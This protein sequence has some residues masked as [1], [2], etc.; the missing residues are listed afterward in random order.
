MRIEPL[1]K[2]DESF[3]DKASQYLNINKYGGFLVKWAHALESYGTPRDFVYSTSYEPALI[4]INNQI[5]SFIIVTSANNAMRREL[6]AKQKHYEFKDN[7]GSYGV[8]L[9]DDLTSCFLCQNVLQAIDAKNHPGDVGDNVIDDLGLHLILPNRYPAEYGHSLSV[10]RNH[11][12]VTTRVKPVPVPEEKTAMYKPEP[13]KT[14]GNIFGADYLEAAVEACDKYYLIGLRNHVL[15]GMSIPGHDHFQIFPED[16][17]RFSQTKTVTDEKQRTNFGSNVYL[18]QNTPFD[19]LL[20]VKEEK[21]PISDAAIPLLRRLEENDQIFTL[22]Y[23]S[24]ILFV[25]PRIEE[26]FNDKRQQVGACMPIH[27]VDV[28]A[29]ETLRRANTFMPMKGQ[30]DWAKYMP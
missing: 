11:D 29:E 20:I 14:R 4:K 24:G 27:S 7:L 19:T 12:D 16:L 8:R 1:S 13:G 25:S 10:L 22:F 26:R 6:M 9:A 17:P 5:Y 2:E 23:Q 30:Y 21:K 28:P 18:A 3:L 15:E